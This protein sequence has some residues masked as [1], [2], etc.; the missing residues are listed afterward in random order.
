MLLHKAKSS[1]KH[2][3]QSVALMKKNENAKQMYIYQLYKPL[4]I[5]SLLASSSGPVKSLSFEINDKSRPSSLRRDP[6]LKLEY[7]VQSARSESP[8]V[9]SAI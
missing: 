6:P 3:I 2:L 8:N 9:L 4:T 5:S 1:K 7:C